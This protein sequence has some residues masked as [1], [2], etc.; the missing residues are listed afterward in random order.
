MDYI[1][2]IDQGTTG[3]TAVL[4]DE[5]LN[6]KSKVN[7]EY[8]Q[9][10]PKMG[11][12]EHN[13]KDIWNS[14]E[15]SIIK[16]IEKS[17]INTKEIKAI[18]ITNQRETVTLWNKFTGRAYHNFIV[19][20]DRRTADYCSMM[21]GK[22]YEELISEKTGLLLDPYFS[23][24]KIRWI[25]K[26][27]KE[28]QNAS[29]R[30]E[31][32]AGTIDT[33][34]VYNLTNKKVHVT[35]V[36]NASRTLLMDLKS[37][38]WDTQ[39]CELLEVPI[40]LLP[41][42]S[43]SSE[44]YGYTS[45]LS[46]LPDGIPISGIAGDQQAALFGQACFKQGEAKATYGTGSFILMNTG[47]KIVHSKNR[48]LTTVAWKIGDK[49]TYALEGSAFIAGALVQWIRDEMDF[50]KDAAEIEKLASTVENNG[51]VVIIPS[52]TGMGAPYWRADLQ[53]MIY[54]ISRNTSRAHIARAALEA[55]ALQNYDLLKAME[56]D[57][58]LK[59][60]NLKVDG[61]ASLNNL[62]MQFQSDILDVKLSR[63][64]FIETTALGAALLA[65][66]SIGLFKNLDDIKKRWK[67][68]QQY[69]PNQNNYVQETLDRYKL[70]IRKILTH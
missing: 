4:I 25:L 32:I 55:I 40:S 34:L 27:V 8:K 56:K 21:K 33:F 29:L 5:F 44:V 54:G 35:D 53:G 24:T 23:G 66:L 47:D 16:L 17:N 49:V 2:A 41:K 62:L 15:E 43:S 58:D 11:W 38:D 68:N 30:K 70:V 42:I 14:V 18:G 63:P 64:D 12:V 36:S 46:F 1:L 51:G 48:L 9:I 69:T 39:L 19:W 10:Y 20:Q 22:G 57:T 37:L 52:L 45:G 28:A 3:T 67:L 6:I 13:P 50:I 26:N 61:G 31:A 59:L 65:G 7:V 60:L